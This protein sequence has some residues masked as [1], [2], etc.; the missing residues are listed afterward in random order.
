MSDV[1]NRRKQIAKDGRRAK[2]YDWLEEKEGEIDLETFEC[3]NFLKILSQLNFEIG[4]FDTAGVWRW[5]M[6]GHK[7][8]LISHVFHLFF[9]SDLRT[10]ICQHAPRF[11]V[12][13]TKTF[14]EMWLWWKYQQTFLLARY[15]IRRPAAGEA[16]LSSIP[17]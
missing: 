13:K 11:S 8:G 16:G 12:D 7:S 9:K 3:L 14:W 17:Y 6:S 15:Q 5:N 4:H 10:F 2:I 1:V